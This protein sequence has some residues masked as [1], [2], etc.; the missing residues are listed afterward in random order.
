MSLD[1]VLASSLC[2]IS[3]V[4]T[5]EDPYEGGRNID[6]IF[7]TQSEQ[8][9]LVFDRFSTKNTS[10]DAHSLNSCID[11]PTAPPFFATVAVS[12]ETAGVLLFLLDHPLAQVPLASAE[13]RYQRGALQRRLVQSMQLGVALVLLLAFDAVHV[14]ALAP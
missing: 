9:L 5:D 6:H 8:D 14:Q 7:K 2:H 3:Y 1:V 13:V 12:P 4:L 11:L 10:S